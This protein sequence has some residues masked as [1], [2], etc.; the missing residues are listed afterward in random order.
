MLAVDGF[1]TE[2]RRRVAAQSVR[3]DA[4]PRSAFHRVKIGKKK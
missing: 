1:M 3:D 4:E 2:D